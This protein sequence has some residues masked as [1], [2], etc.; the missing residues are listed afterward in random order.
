MEK[1]H[2]TLIAFIIFLLQVS[3]EL[4]LFRGFFF[5]FQKALD[6]K[7]VAIWQKILIMYF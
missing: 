2:P 4:I 1:F 3:A 6:K 5:L 7:V